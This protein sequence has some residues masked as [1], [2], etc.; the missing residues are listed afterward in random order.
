M[1]GVKAPNTP[2]FSA[3]E[4]EK[5]DKNKHIEHLANVAYQMELTQNKPV[6]LYPVMSARGHLNRDFV[7]LV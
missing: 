5:G 1:F 6:F 4:Q 2:A 3:T 7:T